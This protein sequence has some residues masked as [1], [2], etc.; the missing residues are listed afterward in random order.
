MASVLYS[1][2]Q[3]DVDA[4][5]RRIVALTSFSSDQAAS[6]AFSLLCRKVLKIKSG[7]LAQLFK[8]VDADVDTKRMRDE[9]I[10]SGLVERIEGTGLGG[11]P[12]VY[13]IN[14]EVS[15][16]VEPDGE[17]PEDDG[18]VSADDAADAV[19][20]AVESAFDAQMAGEQGPVQED[21]PFDGGSEAEAA[22]PA[23][24]ETET[25]EA[26]NSAPESQGTPEFVSKVGRGSR[27]RRHRRAGGGAAKKE[28][29][30]P[31]TGDEK[32]AE[33]SRDVPA[34]Q[35]IATGK[36]VACAS[37]QMAES[38]SQQKLERQPRA[39]QKHSHKEQVAGK[40]ASQPKATAT[41]KNDAASEHA[42]PAQ[43]AADSSEQPKPARKKRKRSRSSNGADR[44]NSQLQPTV[45]APEQVFEAKPVEDEPAAKRL[46]PFVFA[47]TFAARIAD[48][49]KLPAPLA[50]LKEKRSGIV[51]VHAE[52]TPAPEQPARATHGNPAKQQLNSDFA[53]ITAWIDQ[54]HGMDVPYASRRQRA[55]QIFNDE[56]AFDG[57]RG[58]RL[59]KRL[60]D[61]GVNVAALKITPQRPN[62]FQ[63][64]FSIGADKPFIVVENIDTYDEIARLLRGNT[65]I[66]LFGLRISGVIFGSGCK[67][68]VSHALDDFLADVGYR[69]DY[70]YYAGDIDREGARIIE[71]ARAANN[72]GIRM[73]AGMYKAMLATHRDRVKQ[74]KCVEPA[75]ENQ[76]VPQNLARAIAD[77]PMVTRVQFRNIL[78]EGGRI[79]QEILT[80]ADYRDSASGAFD[81]LING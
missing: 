18:A 15:A 69:Y 78:R 33:P 44:A 20:V 41:V 53:T 17:G 72:I 67:A 10:K 64:F 45:P 73:H 52:V 48:S 30:A 35:T 47:R 23:M 25:S 29:D 27:I 26:P 9:F 71:Q 5:A 2:N 36:P 8:S 12:A 60:N 63:S 46:A 19:E 62:H 42:T 3:S 80:S 32:A 76:G 39:T 28:Q 14:A 37:E 34:G 43:P 75:S 50:K 49:D 51:K 74:G 6:V 31:E 1:D 16:I 68:S 21:S 22:E 57:K 79:P 65:S 61:R 13:T 54:A 56:K 70:V 11:K 77:L 7:A 38:A 66:K 81:R 59:F 24:N 4:L 58:E 40:D 55:F